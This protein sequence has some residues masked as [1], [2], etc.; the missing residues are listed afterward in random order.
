MSTDY[1]AA[2]WAHALTLAGPPGSIDSLSRSLA[3]ARVDLNP[4]QVDA[5]LFALQS[6]LQRGVLLADEVGL[7]K[8]IEAGL[9]IA[10]RWAERRRQLLLIVPATLRKQWQQEL[11]DKFHLPTRILDA[12]SY[13]LAR[14]GGQPQPFAD[15]TRVQV[16]SY[17][18]ATAKAAEIAAVAWDLV[19]VDE[20]HRLRNV[21]R[22][23][24]K[25]ATAIK[26]AITGR[27]KLLLTATPLQN[28][29][30]ELYGLVSL[31]DDYVFGDLE[32]FREQF[33]RAA[34]ENLRNARLR[35][36]LETFCRR[37]LRRQVLEYVQFT[38]RT[39]ITQRFV[40]SNAEQE[41]YDEVSAY[42]QREVLH[43]LPR[44]QRNLLTLVLRKLLAS[45][46]FAIA[47]TLDSLVRRLE[48][49]EGQAASGL[50]DEDDY[51]AIA[52]VGD[53]WLGN[54]STSEPAP[55]VDL[56]SLRAELAELRRYAGH[57]EA[58]EH[59]TKGDALVDALAIALARAQGLG[60][61]RKAVIFT[62]SRRT[63]AYLARFLAE[64][65]HAGEIVLINGSNADPTSRQIYERWLARHRGSDRVSGSRAAD[66]KAA[67]VEEFQERGTLL[68]AT[69]SAAEGVNLQFCSLVVN[70]DLP[71]NPQR[72]EQRIG[73]CH[74]YGQRHDVVV[75][76][77]LNERNA[78]DQRVFQLLAEKFQLFHGVFGASEE[79]LGAVES[80]VDIE[81]R[82]AEAYQTCRTTAEIQQAFDRLQAELEGQIDSRMRTTREAI[83][84]HF[85][86]EVHR[87]LKDLRDDAQRNLD[88]Q[89]SLLWR[90]A[91]HE[92]AGQA[93]SDDERKCFSV[94]E[95]NG[96]PQRPFFLSWPIADSEDGVFF[97]PAHEL[98]ASLAERARDRALS[99]GELCFRYAPPPRT[100]ALEPHLG[101]SGWLDVSR[102]RVAGRH[103]EEHLVVVAQLDD[104]TA[105]P[106]DLAARLFDLPASVAA[107]AEPTHAP[108]SVDAQRQS[109]A[110]R[111]LGEARVRNHELLRSEEAKLEQWA[112]DAKEGLERDL[113]DLDR[114]IKEARRTSKLAATL[115][116]K[117][118]LQRRMK[119]LEG[120][121]NRKRR[122]LF[123]E[124]DAI[125]AK[126]EQLI[127]EIERQL[128]LTVEVTEVFRCRFSLE[129]S[130]VEPSSTRPNDPSGAAPPPAPGLH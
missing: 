10:Q 1:H 124:Q 45:S 100:M 53:E 32:S 91:R 29:L 72:I 89:Q 84:E 6:P 12:A 19:V 9:V 11:L 86:E 56:A 51:E 108:S 111:L 58:I 127:A 95:A 55:A 25:I 94:P 120:R 41:L 31:L 85:D 107:V 121:R 28:S 38:Q 112:D 92:L 130:G 57:A 37:T 129:S 79:I 68:I 122:E 48:R 30:L 87:R 14:D 2:Y 49:L 109:A 81:R 4:H 66:L 21:Y 123:D 46:T 59:N 99:D 39:P 106:S 8:T 26:G 113:K 105:L 47:G 115:D 63:Q 114:E 42:L 50:L 69:E 43:A 103:V 22:E 44:G 75:V 118:V 96:R 71:W 13:R 33:V 34:D 5:A 77:F 110:D 97:H 101:K 36:R 102:L 18:F 116:E 20:A 128:A 40:P 23:T 27:P 82:I 67:L 125:E 3:S 62:E 117:L 35:A 70:Y 54:D 83:F 16:C 60:A 24:S 119:E 78:A 7:G 65:G 15:S 17:Q 52:E 104:G 64:H 90:L 76:N 98:A 88:G 126:R 93:T 61:A 74:R 80:G 73:R